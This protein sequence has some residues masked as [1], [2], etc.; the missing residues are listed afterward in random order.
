MITIGAITMAAIGTGIATGTVT[1]TVAQ[2][3]LVI[4]SRRRIVPAARPM[5]R[6][7]VTG[8]GPRRDQPAVTS[9]TRIADVPGIGRWIY[10]GHRGGR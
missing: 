1:A 8:R 3:R 9:A 7:F 5:T 10:S 4:R 6:W 2:T